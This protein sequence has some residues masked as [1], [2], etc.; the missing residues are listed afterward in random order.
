MG[1]IADNLSKYT[2]CNN[3]AWKGNRLK[4]VALVATDR[5]AWLLELGLVAGETSSLEFIG[6]MRSVS[7][8]ITL[9]GSED[10]LLSSS[11]C[12]PLLN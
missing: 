10:G 8:V 7:A 12:L 11:C 3:G 6:T 4:C 2:N 5:Y 9:L 1:H